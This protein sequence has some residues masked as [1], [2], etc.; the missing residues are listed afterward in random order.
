MAGAGLE[1]F[2]GLQQQRRR[3]ADEQPHVA[4]GRARQRGFVQESH[5]EC[6]HA[7]EDGRLG[8]VRDH[9][10][11]VEPVHPDRPAAVEQRAVRRHEQAMDMEDR[12]RVD[13]HV[14]R[15]P[16]PIVLQDPGV[17]Q[18]VGVAEHR[19]LAAAGGAA[20]VED[21][22]QV[23]GASCRRPVAVGLDRGALQQAAAAGVVE[24]VDVRAAGR[25]REPADPAEGCGRAHHHRRLGVA[26]EVGHLVTLVGGVE[27]QVDVAGPQHRQVEHQRFDRFFDLH[28]DAA[29]GGQVQRVEQVGEHR[30]AA[31]QVAPGVAQRRGVG[32]L[33]RDRVEV[34]GKPVAQREVE[35]G[36]GH[37]GGLQARC[38]RRSAAFFSR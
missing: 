3:A 18:Q 22:G 6:R 21:R 17:A 30:G 13:Q 19:A 5:V 12:Q 9:R 20:G 14:A 4:A 32:G 1:Q 11:R 37:R 8:Q 15:A 2:E 27:R 35:V 28:R 25:E 38:F 31:V 24:G 34:V 23:V 10:A 26:D 29:A 7:H 16:A 33:D 36:R